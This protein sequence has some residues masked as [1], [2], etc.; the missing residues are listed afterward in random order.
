MK[1][2]RCL[3]FFL[4]AVLAASVLSL[5]SLA[6]EGDAPALPEDPD[7][8]AKAALLV[9]LNTGKAVYAKNEHQELY[10]ASLTKI[11]TALLVLDAVEDGRLTLDQELTASAVVTTLPADGS[12]AN[13]KEGEI[14][15][16]RDLLS[17]MLVVSANEAADILAEGVAGTVEAF[18]ADMNLKA[19]A[20]GCQNTHFVNPNGLHDPQHY[21]S[22][23]DL[24]LITQAAME[25]SVFMEICDTAN[26]VIPATNL[27][28]ERNYWTTNH[29][30]S[31]YRVLGYRNK[32]AHGIKT[33]ST[34]EA[35]YCLVSSAEKGT[36]HF[37]SV[38]MGAERVVEN[39]VGNIRS[40][41]ETTR[42]FNW[43]FDNFRYQTILTDHASIQE[44]PVTLSKT[45]HVIAEAA[46]EVEA[47]VPNGLRPDQLERTV[48]LYHDTL[49]APV[50]AGEK[51]GTLTLSYGDTVYGTVDLL[52]SHDVEVS[53][54]MV[55]WR[56]TGLFFQKTSVR[57]AL[58]ALLVVLVLILLWRLIFS[59]RRYRYGK[60]VGRS[61]A[62][63]YR[64]RR[65]H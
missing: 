9:D 19:A 17:C 13:I 44:I 37:L 38:I 29:L 25:Y 3:S 21:T 23:W 50:T 6:A 18:V 48:D 31:T 52:A 30:L 10:P 47:L 16:V 36:K 60:S 54:L 14:L 2:R 59:R 57:V 56:D 22:A 62:G 11:M 45:D 64:G 53:R 20:L 41:S 42:L 39:N 8:L 12:T 49:E 32:D 40:F 4:L 27:S 26:V 63:G 24:A 15:S 5:Q 35:G 55:F 33:G 34:S 61:G 28:K 58:A 7:I 46:E 1:I 65:R 43:G 51:L